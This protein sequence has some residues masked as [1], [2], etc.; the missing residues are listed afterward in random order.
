M[1]QSPSGGGQS[2]PGTVGLTTE[3][4]TRVHI[5]PWE[6]QGGR[7]KPSLTGRERGVALGESHRRFQK[8]SEMTHSM[9]FLEL[10][11]H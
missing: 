10:A 3:G 1:G 2:L 8:N 6:V 11:H 5:L 7:G 9:I 4:Q